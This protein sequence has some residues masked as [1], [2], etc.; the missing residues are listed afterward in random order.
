VTEH[1]SF[2]RKKRNCEE[3][4]FFFSHVAGERYEGGARC[5][6]GEAR[7]ATVFVSCGSVNEIVS[8]N[9][10]N[11]CQYQIQFTS[12]TACTQAQLDELQKQVELDNALLNEEQEEVVV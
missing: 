5:W 6:G 10:P 4:L 1:S 9:E 8:V 12:P 7:S 2:C 3:G 11:R